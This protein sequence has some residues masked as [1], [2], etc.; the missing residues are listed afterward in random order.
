MII[1]NVFLNN[2]AHG[3]FASIYSVRFP[4]MLGSVILTA[5]CNFS[6]LNRFS[7]YVGL[8]TPFSL[9]PKSLRTG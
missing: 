6:T 4:D 9:T 1:K 7:V 8:Y 3:L 5:Y 2:N